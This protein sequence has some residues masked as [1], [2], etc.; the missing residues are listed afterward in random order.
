MNTSIK[1]MEKYLEGSGTHLPQS[2]KDTWELGDISELV[3][4]EI[5]V[6]LS[7]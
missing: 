6:I 1:M 2:F 5:S 7:R 4:L 3:Q